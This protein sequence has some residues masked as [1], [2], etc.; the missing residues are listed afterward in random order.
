VATDQDEGINFENLIERNLL[1]SVLNIPIGNGRLM[2]SSAEVSTDYEFGIT[3]TKDSRDA[4]VY[5]PNSS[6]KA[7]GLTKG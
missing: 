3:D 5:I 7:A 4:K 2:R 1:V 6:F